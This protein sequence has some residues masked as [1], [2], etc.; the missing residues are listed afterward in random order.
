[1]ETFLQRNSSNFGED[2]VE[3]NEMK[4]SLKLLQWIHKNAEMG[5]M[6]I[7]PVMKL[8]SDKKLKRVLK[9]QFREY[10]LISKESA[11][12]IRK[13]GEQPKTPDP[14]VLSMCD[15]MIRLTG[16][17]KN[18]DSKLSEMMIKGSTNGT[19]QMTRRLR[20]CPDADEH[21]RALGNKLLHTE[22]RNIQQMK[23]FL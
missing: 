12:R 2:S 10:D 17:R 19:I 18:A 22:E 6:T 9:D 15:M 20:D 23:S 21:L 13:Y 11:E 7:P 5:C 14:L 16:K 8:T 4:D 3:V 1:M